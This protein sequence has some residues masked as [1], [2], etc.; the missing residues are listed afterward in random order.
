MSIWNV[1]SFYFAWTFRN[2]FS[3]HCISHAN[4]GSANVQ[5]NCQ[6]MY[7]TVLW[8]TSMRSIFYQPMW[9][10]VVLCI[11][12]ASPIDRKYSCAQYFACQYEWIWNNYV[13][14]LHITSER[15]MKNKITNQ[16]TFQTGQYEQ[17]EVIHITHDKSLVCT[18]YIEILSP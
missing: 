9:M 5:S 4:S 10:N 2:Y 7:I 14:K 6:Q 15:S 16:L 18:I 12:P 3:S 8:D 11:L 17:W 1:M 13:R